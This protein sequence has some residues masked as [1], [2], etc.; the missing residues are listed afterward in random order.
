MIIIIIIIIISSFINDIIIIRSYY[1]LY[2]IMMMWHHLDSNESATQDDEMGHPK[3]GGDGPSGMGG[4]GSGW[5]RRPLPMVTIGLRL[6]Q[7][8]PL[9]AFARARSDGRARPARRPS[10]VLLQGHLESRCS[11]GLDGPLSRLVRLSSQ[12][13]HRL[14]SS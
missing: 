1:I 11:C 3:D 8:E 2:H 6:V 7:S 12:T 9:R 4:W 13:L 14:W 5:S 10:T